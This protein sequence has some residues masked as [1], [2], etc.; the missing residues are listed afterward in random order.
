MKKIALILV[1]FCCNFNMLGQIAT[2]TYD[3]KIKDQLDRLGMKY[4]ITDGGNFKLIINF[5][6]NRSQVVIVYS[7]TWESESTNLTIREISAPIYKNSYIPTNILKKALDA[8]YNEILGSFQTISTEENSLLLYTLKV[9][10]VVPDDLLKR[11]INQCAITADKYEES[12]FGSD[13]Y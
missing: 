12:F 5:T 2:A 3:S 4:E 11:L 6:D 9:N 1:L 13:E 10:D 7:K 8:N